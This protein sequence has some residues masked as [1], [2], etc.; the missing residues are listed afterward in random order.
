MQRLLI[1]VKDKPLS[2]S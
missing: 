2:F 1:C